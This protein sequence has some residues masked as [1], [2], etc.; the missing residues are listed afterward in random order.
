MAAH[1]R[2]I[3]R[4][5]ITAALKDAQTAAGSRVYEHPRNDRTVFPSLVVEDYGSK[6]SDGSATEAQGL[7]DMAGTIERHY[8][9]VV[10]AEVKSAGSP[11][12]ERDDLIAQV[13]IAIEAALQAGAIP[14]A[15]RITPMGYSADDADDADQAI[16]RGIQVFDVLYFTPPGDPT[17]TL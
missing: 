5:A 16:R 3:I 10:I 7:M 13:E 9:C 14:G 8:R 6:H 12:D 1:A 17:T 11:A 2:K 15:K 4:K